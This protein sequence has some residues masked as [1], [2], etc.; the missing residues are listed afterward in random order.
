MSWFT[1]EGNR[2]SIG[3][4]IG[5]GP[6]G[7]DF[8]AAVAKVELSEIIVNSQGGDI[9]TANSVRRFLREMNLRVTVEGVAASAAILVV[10][11]GSVVRIRENA[12]LGF[13]RPRWSNKSGD[14]GDF[15]R[16]ADRLD[17]CLEQ[18]VEILAA[19]CKRDP[20]IVRAL[21]VSEAT[22]TASQTLQLGFAHEIIPAGVL[23][24]MRA[25]R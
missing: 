22:L 14:A 15:R 9:P 4:G 25:G 11:G 8:A 18:Q 24:A 17:E 2:V 1:I 12:Q 23:Q 13:H 6:D 20:A 10:A 19:F 16:W 7:T 3:D 5:D 21:I